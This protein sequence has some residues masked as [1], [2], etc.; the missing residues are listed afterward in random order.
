MARYKVLKSV[1]HGFGHSFTSLLNYRDH[2][3]VMGHLL[4]RARQVGEGTLVVD[5]LRRTA[6][7]ATLVTR[8]V[9]A[10]LESYCAWFPRLVA[11]HR[12]SL[13]FIRAARMSIAFDVATERPYRDA[14]EYLESPYVC[15]VE[16]ED[17]RG[18]FWAA[19]LRGWWF[20]ELGAPTPGGAGGAAAGLRSV[21][22]RLGQYIR[23][24]WGRGRASSQA[25]A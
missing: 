12:T 6:A 20:P 3:Y 11:S 9:A 16:I 23:S 24:T 1:A 4:R 8:P 5:I 18:R 19:E 22:R 2:D 7:P 17:D 25:A 14:P 21:V 13:E 10:S 15:R